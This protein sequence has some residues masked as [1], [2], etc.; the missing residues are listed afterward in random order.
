MWG[1]RSSISGA[2]IVT[3]RIRAAA[4]ALS[5]VNIMT[6][7]IP[8]LL[9]YVKGKNEGPENPLRFRGLPTENSFLGASAGAPLLAHSGA[10]ARTRRGRAGARARGGRAPG[11]CAGRW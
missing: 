9:R 6:R 7:D 4:S 11:P 2:V 5:T 10:G 3:V 1:R 8:K